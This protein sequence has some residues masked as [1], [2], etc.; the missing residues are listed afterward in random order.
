[1]M[2]PIETGPVRRHPQGI[3]NTEAVSKHRNAS[4]ARDSAK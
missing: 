2:F 3:C 4:L 1:M